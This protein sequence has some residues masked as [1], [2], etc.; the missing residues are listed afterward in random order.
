MSLIEGHDCGVL[1]ELGLLLVL[2]GKGYRLT[3][4]LTLRIRSSFF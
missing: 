1:R 4:S 3:I 2:V